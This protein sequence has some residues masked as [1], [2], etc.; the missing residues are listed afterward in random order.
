MPKQR[1]VTK[2]DTDNIAVEKD[3]AESASENS[4]AYELEEGDDEAQVKKWKTQG[5]QFS[6]DS[7]AS[8]LSKSIKHIKDQKGPVA[9]VHYDTIPAMFPVFAVENVG[10]IPFPLTDHYA[11]ELKRVASLA[12]FGKGT[13]TVVDT[14]VRHTFEVNPDKVAFLN[15]DFVAEVQNVACRLATTLN[16]GGSIRAE[17]HRLLLYEPG[18]FFLPHRDSEKQPGMF[19]TLVISLPCAESAEGGELIVSHGKEQCTFKVSSNSKGF[20]CFGFFCNCLHEIKPLKGGRRLTLVFKVIASEGTFRLPTVKE[21][22]IIQKA[23]E[24]LAKLSTTKGKTNDFP[25][26]VSILDHE[27][28]AQALEALGLN[29]LKGVDAIVASLLSRLDQ[30]Q[31]GIGALKITGESDDAVYYEKYARYSMNSA[32]HRYD[33]VTFSLTGIVPLKGE[34]VKAFQGKKLSVKPE[35]FLQNIDKALGDRSAI[36]F[37]GAEYTGNEARPYEYRYNLSAIIIWTNL[38]KNETDAKLTHDEDD[39]DGEEEEEEEE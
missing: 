31:F 7:A 6:K 32:L 9:Y 29:G 8:I 34:H 26:L 13:K 20:E 21:S 3:V 35:Y 38:A 22:S 25:F 39:D 37:E 28:S 24:E 11:S 36:V 5:K 16:V 23:S 15:Q 18:S 33:Y 4:S 2:K 27:Y 12:P 19:A 1:K 14:S 10:L 30:V 17:L